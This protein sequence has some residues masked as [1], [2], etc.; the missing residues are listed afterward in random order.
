MP[1]LILA[2]DPGPEF[3]AYC[4]IRGGDLS[5]KD[6]AKVETED[7]IT[8]LTEGGLYHD[9]VLEEC[10]CRKWAGREVSDTAFVAGRMYQASEYIG[11]RV[12]LVSRSKVRGHWGVKNDSQIIHSMICRFEPDVFADYMS[13]RYTRGQMINRV[14]KTWFKGFKEDIWQA[15]ALGVCFIDSNQHDIT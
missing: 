12:T 13:K 7:L 4:V 5:V 6:C 11:K 2:V 3:S 14:K 15:Y 8:Q 10:I 9:V 1:A